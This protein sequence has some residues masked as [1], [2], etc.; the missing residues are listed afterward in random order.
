MP[1]LFSPPAV[2][3]LRLSQT[4]VLES[5]DGPGHPSQQRLRAYLDSVTT[6]VGPVLAVDTSRL[7]LTLD[8]GLADH[9]ALTH[10][11][12]D[13][14]NY[15]FPLARRFGAGRFDAV[16]ARKRHAAASTKRPATRL[17]PWITS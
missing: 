12:N 6:L 13:L 7:A 2:T 10:G 15:L 9:I 1:T 3:P 8:V 14:D 5:W 4:P 16:F 17:C 11:G